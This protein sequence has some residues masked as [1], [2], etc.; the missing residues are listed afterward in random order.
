[1]TDI[2]KDQEGTQSEPEEEKNGTTAQ[3]ESPSTAPVSAPSKESDDESEDDSKKPEDAPDSE[4]DAPEMSF[5]AHMDELRK[6]LTRCLIAAGVGFLACYYFSVQLFDILMAPLVKVLPPESTL[7]YTSLPEGFFTYVKVAMVA[8][9]FLA[10]PYIFYQI[11]MF[12]IPGLYPEERKWLIPIAILSA[13]CFTVGATFG[14]S[15]VFPFGF[16]FFMDFATETIRPM[17]TLSE[18]L[19]FSLKLLFAFGTIFELP[20][21]IFFL[22]RLGIVSAKGLRRVRKYA[23]MCAFIVS[24]ILTPPDVISQL[25][26]SGPLLILYEISIWVA[27]FFGK[28][29]RRET[30]AA[31]EDDAPKDAPKDAHEDAKDSAGDDAGEKTG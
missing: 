12:I 30:E 5:L 9:I 23:I 8:G 13:V 19:S 6:R 26:M 14:Y 4:E 2:P 24:A 11:W 20:L 1:M 3:E 25:F 10:S 15:V 29:S 21:F 27:H 7:I 16:Q 18:Y 31:T 17:P 28:K 22:A